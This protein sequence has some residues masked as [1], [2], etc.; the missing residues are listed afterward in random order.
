MFGYNSIR[1]SP[2]NL[3]KQSIDYLRRSIIVVLLLP[4]RWCPLLSKNKTNGYLHNK[5]AEALADEIHR[6]AEL[7]PDDL[8]H[9]SRFLIEINSGLLTN[10]H[11]EPQ[12]Y[13]VTAM[14]PARKAKAK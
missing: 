2:H 11:V 10:T 9:D 13:W 3:N 1:Y 4:S 8:L 5:T 12:A 14:I 7:E 6:L